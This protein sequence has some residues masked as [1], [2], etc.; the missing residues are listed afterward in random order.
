MITA[1]PYFAL[2]D[3]PRDLR[4]CVLGAGGGAGVLLALRHAAREVDAVELNPDVPELLRG[5]FHHFAGGLYEKPEV[6]LHRADA[7]AFVQSARKKW[8]VID[9]SLVDSFAASAVGVGAVNESYLYTREAIEAFLN[10]LRPGGVLAVTRWARTPPRD[11]LK[12]FATAA[13]SL[14]RMRPNPRG[15]L[16]LIRSW[17][18]ATLLVKKES[19]TNPELSTLR[20]WA[21]ERFIDTSY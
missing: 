19:F 16:V 20:R 1:A 13:A 6:R 14:E 3:A 10:H 2:Q 8:D 5:E 17:D 4:V 21:E 9:L 12:L 18:I 11:G 7:R 15:R